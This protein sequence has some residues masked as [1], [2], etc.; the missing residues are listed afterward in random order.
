MKLLLKLFLVFRY[1]VCG[2]SDHGGSIFT[3][4]SVRR[5]TVTA[6]TIFLRPLVFRHSLRRLDE[7][8]RGVWWTFFSLSH[9]RSIA[10]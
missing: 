3:C 6:W 7:R 2:S 1:W 8:I 4:P 5:A 9:E 10:W